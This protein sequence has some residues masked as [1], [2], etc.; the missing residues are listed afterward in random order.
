MSIRESIASNIV[1]TLTAITSP[2]TVKYVN[3][4]DFDFT[5]LS[6]AQFPALLVTTTSESRADVTIGDSATREA[7][8][9]YQ[10]EGYVKTT[11]LDTSR[12][13]LAEAIEEALDV[14]RTRGG[15]AKDTQI[16]S[17]EIDDGTIAPF[18]AVLVTVEVMYTF[19]RGTT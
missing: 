6:S 13:Q 5:K 1:S 19:T 10:I 18:A 3:R 7:T 16:T 11:T 15:Y 9:S 4:D 14:D 2:V 12:N 17:I 8:I